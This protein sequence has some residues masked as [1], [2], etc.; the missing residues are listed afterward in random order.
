MCVGGQCKTGSQQS[1]RAQERTGRTEQRDGAYQN[2]QTHC[3]GLVEQV[4]QDNCL[5]SVEA[6]YQRRGQK[7]S[8]RR[9]DT[10]VQPGR[11]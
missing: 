9:M 11:R 1:G 7:G 10:R 3:Q 8:G 2:L 5:A 4:E 6:L